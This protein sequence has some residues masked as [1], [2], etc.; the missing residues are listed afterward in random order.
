MFFDDH[1]RFL[2]TSTTASNRKRL[3]LRHVAM[4]RSHQ[5]IFPGAKVLDIASHDGRWSM[6]AH[7]MGA[8]HVTGIEVSP[9]LVKSAHETFDHYA[10]DPARYRFVNDDVFDVLA[11]PAA[12]GLDVDVVMCLGFIY[13]TLRYQ[14]L[15]AGVRALRPKHFLIDT[16]VILSDEPMVKL[17]LEDTSKESA[18]DDHSFAHEG[19]LV[20]GRPSVSALELLLEGHGFT[21]ERRFDWPTFIAEKHPNTRSVQSYRTGRRVTWLCVPA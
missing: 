21:V 8:Q 2:E 3:N 20:T 11:D 12:H 18:G 9:Q 17:N 16:A 5:E 13:H 1:P 15:F 7:R 14:E 19:T 6:A 10:V 4:F